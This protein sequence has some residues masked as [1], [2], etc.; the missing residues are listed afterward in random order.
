MRGRQSSQ[1][2]MFSYVSLEE[3][4]PAKHPL[5]AIRAVVDE[6]LAGM[7]GAFA[8][9]YASTGRPS[10]P[11][12]Q[13]LKALLLQA[14]YSIRSERQLVEQ[15]DFNLLFRWFVGLGIDDA[16]WHPTV[17]T[18]NRDRL[19][20]GDVAGA[21]LGAVVAHARVKGLL[22]DEH[23]SV[24]GTLIEAWAS[25]KSFRPKDGGGEPPGP[26]R[27]GERDFHGERRRNDTHVSVTDP[28]AR[29]FRKGRGKE[30]KLSFM[31]HVLM[32]NRNG[33]VVGATLTQASGF[34]ER[35]AAV[36]LIGAMPG[37]HRITVGAD[38]GYDTADFVADLR[39]FK[40]TPHV[41]RNTAGRRSRIDA[42]TTRHPGYTLSQRCRKRI[43]EVFGTGEKARRPGTPNVAQ[44]APRR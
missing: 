34:A 12:E 44:T 37:R 42:R 35:G 15:L 22:S 41:A 29:L 43:E 21:F 31:G 33:L 23:F 17:F 25:V 40:A 2:A 18:K 5:R 39:T 10:I 1:G 32:E 30:A 4:V 24:D 11:P 20:A 27:N 9:L 6:V 14:F 3:R 16:I 8:G 19:L 7:D 28:E 38:K 13:V 26:G 36:A